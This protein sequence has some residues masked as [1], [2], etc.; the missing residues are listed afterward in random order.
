MERASQA[1]MLKSSPLLLE[2]FDLIHQDAITE[3]YNTQPGEL[4]AA[5]PH[6]KLRAIKEIRD[7]LDSFINDE[8]LRSK[9]G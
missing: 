5:A 2:I 6:A 1:E 9:R 7:R 4:T 8:I 3:L